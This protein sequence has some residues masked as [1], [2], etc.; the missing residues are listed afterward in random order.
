MVIKCSLNVWLFFL[1]LWNLKIEYQPS[2]KL[3]FT[4]IN[5]VNITVWRKSYLFT[6]TEQVAT[7][8]NNTKESKPMGEINYILQ[9]WDCKAEKIYG[10]GYKYSKRK[11]IM[12]Y[13]YVQINFQIDKQL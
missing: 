9:I 2:L 12:S 3:R 4:V 11:P 1:H 10:R 7:T 13:Y 8:E 6:Q 5:T